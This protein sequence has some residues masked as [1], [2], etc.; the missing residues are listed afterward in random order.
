MLVAGMSKSLLAKSQINVIWIVYE[1]ENM[2]GF[3]WQASWVGYEDVP[4]ISS[5]QTDSSIQINLTRLVGPRAQTHL[6]P[7]ARSLVTVCSPPVAMASSCVQH[8]NPIIIDNL[9]ISDGC[10]DYLPES[11][12]I[13]H[14]YNLFKC[15]QKFRQLVF[16]QLKIVKWWV[17]NTAA[18]THSRAEESL[19]WAR[20]R[21]TLRNSRLIE[22]FCIHCGSSGLTLLTIIVFR[23]FLPLM[24]WSKYCKSFSINSTLLASPR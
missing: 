21:P 4:T 15:N 10:C 24:I 20:S 17:V 22:Y 11:F 3:S 7:W 5:T 1:K 2:V 6:T 16:L 12:V 13:L 23:Y 9:S 14:P 19:I 18:L 8:L